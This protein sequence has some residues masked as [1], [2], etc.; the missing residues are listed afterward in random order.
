[1]RV[2]GGK[3]CS[4]L[5]VESDCQE[6][7]KL[8]NNKKGS[9]TKIVWVILEIQSL[10]KDFQNISFY[11]TPRSCNAHAHCLAKLALRSNKI[12]GWLEPLPAEVEYVFSSLIYEIISFLLKK[13]L[14]QLMFTKHFTAI[15]FKIQLP[16]LNYKRTLS[17]I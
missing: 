6:V 15:T 5:M 11:H 3:K 4:P 14:Q 1:M 17:P 12:V 10:S 2:S 8:V 9:R 16:N 13:K 7:V